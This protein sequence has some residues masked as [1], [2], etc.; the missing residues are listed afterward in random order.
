[1]FESALITAIGLIGLMFYFDIKKIAGYAVIVDI[2]LM[3][4]MLWVFSGT[5]A[6]MMTGFFASLMITGFLRLVR[7]MFGYK[8]VAI[9]KVPNSPVPHTYWKTTRGRI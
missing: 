4:F 3:L 8:T 5:Y 9:K 7:Y 6:G 1:M 2:V